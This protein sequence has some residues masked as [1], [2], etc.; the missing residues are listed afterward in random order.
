LNESL[1]FMT[2]TRE[3]PLRSTERGEVGEMV[4]RHPRA[5]AAYFIGQSCT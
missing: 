4:L 1:H 5:L 2:D 3:I